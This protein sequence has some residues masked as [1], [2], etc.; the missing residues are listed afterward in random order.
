MPRPPAAAPAL[1]RPLHLILAFV[2]LSAPSIC[3]ARASSPQKARYFGSTLPCIKVDATVGLLKGE[4]K[5]HVRLGTVWP[6][7]ESVHRGQAFATRAIQAACGMTLTDLNRIE[8]AAGSKGDK[9]EFVEGPAAGSGTELVLDGSSYSLYA[10]FDGHNGHEAAQ[11]SMGAIHREIHRRLPV[12]PWPADN[13]ASIHEWLAQLRAAVALALAAVERKFAAA[14]ISSGATCT[15]VLQTGWLITV[16]NLGD[17]SAY[18]DTGSDVVGL[19]EDHRLDDSELERQ[20]L[21][22]YEPRYIVRR[23]DVSLQGVARDRYAGIGPLRVW[24]GGL[25][26][27]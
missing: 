19:T 15:I 2:F 11:F 5:H 7:R 8:R 14:G 12:G 3:F 17:S 20:R 23:L 10:V 16:A 13:E 26:V 22:P 25:A 9:L 6:T 24:P 4:D 18:V 1:R 27:R 21:L